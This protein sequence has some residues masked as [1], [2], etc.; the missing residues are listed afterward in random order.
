MKKDDYEL[1]FDLIKDSLYLKELIF[2]KIKEKEL[3]KNLELLDNATKKNITL[4][5]IS[6]KILSNSIRNTKQSNFELNLKFLIRD[7][8]NILE[9]LKKNKYKKIYFLLNN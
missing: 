6:M 9:E 4:K 8:L 3:D 2:P 1:L 5:K 7:H